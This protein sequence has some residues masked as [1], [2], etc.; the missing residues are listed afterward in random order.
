M[1]VRMTTPISDYRLRRPATW[2]RAFLVIGILLAGLSGQS[3]AAAQVLGAQWLSRA[4][5]ELQTPTAEEV[6]AAKAR[7]LAALDQ[8]TR[9]L[10]G[11]PEGA[12]LRSQLRIDALIDELAASAPAADNTTLRALRA[13]RPGGLEP[14]LSELRA[15]VEA[16]QSLATFDES[17]RAASIE[18][19]RRLAQMDPAAND[20]NQE[21]NRADFAA[22]A[23]LHR[24]DGP[25]AELRA[26][27]SHANHQVFVNAA[28]LQTIGA[29]KFDAPI[30][31]RERRDGTLVTAR[32]S[33]PVQTRLELPTNDRR[34][35]LNLYVDANGSM[36]LT[37]CRGKLFVSACSNV[38]LDGN[39]LFSLN[40]DGV[41]PRDPD[42]S[43]GSR[44]RLT[45]VEVST[46][47][48][49]RVAER[50]VA[51]VATRKLP[52]ADRRAARAA[53]PELEKR[54]AEECG[55]IADRINGLF[56]QLYV[57]PLLAFDV[58]ASLAFCSGP[59]GITGT[60]NYA[61]HDQLGALAPPPEPRV[62]AEAL[63]YMV[64]LHESAIN[65]LAEQWGGKQLDEATFW[66]I[67]NEEFKFRS[68]DVEQLPPGRVSMVVQLADEMPVTLRLRDSG[69]DLS[70]RVRGAGPEGGVQT[71]D[72]TTL[73]IRYDLSP[74]T[75]GI[76][77]KRHGAIAVEPATS[78]LDVSMLER[79]FPVA[80]TP[81]ARFNNAGQE[82]KMVVRDL[83]LDDGWLVLGVG[84]ASAMSASPEAN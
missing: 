3:P 56:Q 20:S 62:P 78:P 41:T 79:F 74:T 67:L 1:N 73:R 18:R 82:Q 27:L 33:L 22:L 46:R 44:T 60:A 15:A 61:R 8:V 59:R 71:D 57:G 65:N 54:V 39:Q 66:M 36:R 77:L 76:S 58:D 63:S 9:H 55:K 6:L 4:E 70:M 83:R 43:L 47:V 80:L 52:D 14:L 32:G 17:A 48:G 10:G 34:A 64:S 84:P 37:A 40:S 42:I 49:G 7:A 23:R 24:I 13:R 16:W 38:C 75:A 72:E 11:L 45:G 5:A 81:R 19:L 21:A 30:D 53:K 50:V 2:L 25:L 69:I 51:K 12:I 35:D 26:R 29:R 68:E 31:V 28:Y